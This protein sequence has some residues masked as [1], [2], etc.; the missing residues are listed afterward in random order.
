ME[1]DDIVLLKQLKKIN[2]C[3][4]SENDINVI[5]ELID[6]MEVENKKK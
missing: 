5:K 1:Y 2:V 4:F 3:K 6:K